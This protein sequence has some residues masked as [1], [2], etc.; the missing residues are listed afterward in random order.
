MA[1]VSPVVTEKIFFHQPPVAVRNVC[2][3]SNSF[4]QPTSS[5]DAG[6]K[7]YQRREEDGD[8]DIKIMDVPL[9]Y[10]PKRPWRRR[11]MV[12]GCAIG[13][14]LVLEPFHAHDMRGA[15]AKLEQWLSI[16]WDDLKEI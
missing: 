11:W 7:G 14:S 5:P 1:I 15:G 3:M 9:S 2:I 4:T 10:P 8:A 12:A 6:G 13:Q 16:Y